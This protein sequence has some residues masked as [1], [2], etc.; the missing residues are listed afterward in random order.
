MTPPADCFA[1]EVEPTDRWRSLP[2]HER[3]GFLIRRLHQI[4]VALFA[5]ECAGEN[6]TPVQYSV[7]TALDHLGT[8]D[9]TALAHAVGLDRT[10]IADVLARLDKRGLIDRRVAT[11]DRR[12][13][14][15]TLT[16]TGRETLV[17][18]ADGASRAHLRTVETLPAQERNAFVEAMKRLVDANNDVG[19]APLLLS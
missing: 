1:T 4:H 2:I 8:A 12:M 3:P 19:R 17:R 10:N 15:A 14:L 6:I 13:K 18:L 5:E 9:Q 11:E 7:L 16:T